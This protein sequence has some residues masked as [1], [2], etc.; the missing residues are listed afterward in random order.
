MLAQ[1]NPAGQKGQTTGGGV[2]KVEMMTHAKDTAH[3]LASAAARGAGVSEDYPTA[4]IVIHEDIAVHESKHHHEGIITKYSKQVP[5]P[6][7]P[8]TSYSS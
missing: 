7:I 3:S 5:I 2:Q 4:S 1:E 8:M 6:P